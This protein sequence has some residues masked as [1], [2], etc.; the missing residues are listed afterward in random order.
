LINDD[1]VG[2][3]KTEPS[4]TILS[5]FGFIN[6]NDDVFVDIFVVFVDIF[7]VFVDIFVVFA[8]LGLGLYNIFT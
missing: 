2:Y 5:V 8:G 4:K 7:V 1:V 6:A 3:V